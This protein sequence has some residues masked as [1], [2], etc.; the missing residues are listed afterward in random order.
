VIK[1]GQNPDV[2]VLVA[3]YH[4]VRESTDLGI[5]AKFGIKN[6]KLQRDVFNPEL[7]FRLMDLAKIGDLTRMTQFKSSS[8][9][10]R[11][12]HL[13]SY[14]VLMVHDVAGYEEVLVGEDQEQHLQYASKLLKKYNSIYKPYHIPTANVVAGRIKDLRNPSKKMS[15]SVPQGCL[16]LDDSPDEMRAKIRKATADD[17]GL[18][19]LKFLYGEF[20]GGEVPEKNEILKNKLSDGI[21]SRFH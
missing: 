15:K 10:D 2:T 19:N 12:A 18:D 9:D 20:V 6:V 16:F 14:P 3:N 8:V 4:A 1:P 7:Y 17:N 21:I 11:T 5:L 13:F